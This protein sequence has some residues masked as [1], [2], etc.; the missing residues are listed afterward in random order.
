M[1]NRGK[2]EADK[3]K[4]P[5]DF[6]EIMIEGSN[7]ACFGSYGAQDG[8]GVSEISCSEQQARRADIILE[9]LRKQ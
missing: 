1:L 8:D 7:H 6:T 5:A 3:E 2:Y 4:L 9:W